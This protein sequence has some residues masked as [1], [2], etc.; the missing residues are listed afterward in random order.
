MLSSTFTL[1]T[2][3]TLYL[4]VPCGPSG[5]AAPRR[6]QIPAASP[7]FYAK[8][9]CELHAAVGAAG[10]PHAASAAAQRQFLFLQVSPKPVKARF[11]RLAAV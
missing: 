6:Q 2:S 3:C 5:R 1:F 8:T 9:R 11:V 7:H 4:A 10:S